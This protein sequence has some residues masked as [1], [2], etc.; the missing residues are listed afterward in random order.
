MNLAC[1]EQLVVK[2]PVGTKQALREVADRRGDEPS[3]YLRKLVLADLQKRTGY[4]AAGR[5]REALRG[6]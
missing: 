6:G 4:S 5:A 3:E 1:P 2:V